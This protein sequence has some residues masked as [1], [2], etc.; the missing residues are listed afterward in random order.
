M[1]KIN[2]FDTVLTPASF[3]DESNTVNFIRNVQTAMKIL[4]GGN[5]T[6]GLG[7][8]AVREIGTN[9]GEVPL[10]NNLEDSV[11]HAVGS[12]NQE[13]PTN[14]LLFGRYIESRMIGTGDDDL[15]LGSQIKA[16]VAANAGSGMGGGLPG[17]GSITHE[18]LGNLIVEADNIAED[19]V[20]RPKILNGAVHP[21]KLYAP[22]QTATP[23]TRTIVTKRTYTG[24]PPPLDDFEFVDNIGL[25]LLNFSGT[26]QPGKVFTIGSNNDIELVDAQTGPPGPTGPQGPA[27]ADGAQGPQ[28][29]AGADGAQGPVG[30][31][32]PPGPTGPPGSGG[33]GGATIGDG[34]LR[35]GA[36][37]DTGTDETK[38]HRYTLAAT[39]E[40][41]TSQQTHFTDMFV[42]RFPRDGY[43]YD[44]SEIKHILGITVTA[45]DGGF[46]TKTWSF[47]VLEIDQIH[48]ASHDPE[49]SYNEY[50]EWTPFTYVNNPNELLIHCAIWENNL[51]VGTANN[52]DTSG[53]GDP[54]IHAGTV[55]IVQ[56]RP[57]IATVE[58]VNNNP[59]PEGPTGPEGPQ[60]P[61]GP[62]GADGV[63]TGSSRLYKYDQ[64]ETAAN[65]TFE[66]HAGLPAIQR[67]APTPSISDGVWRFTANASENSLTFRLFGDWT[68]PSEQAGTVTGDVFSVKM[69]GV[70]NIESENNRD[71]RI[72][73]WVSISRQGAAFT[74]PFEVAAFS[75]RAGSGE[76]LSFALSKF[77]YDSVVG[78]AGAMPGDV[79]RTHFKIENNR[80]NSSLG[81]DPV[82]ANSGYIDLSFS[83]PSFRTYSFNRILSGEQGPQG[84]QGDQGIQ[85]P[86]GIQ[87]DTGPTGPEGPTGPTGPQGPAG[88]I[89]TLGAYS[90]TTIYNNST[91]SF[92]NVVE[93]TLDED[94]VSGAFIEFEFQDFDTQ[95]GYK[96]NDVVFSDTILSLTE[97]STAPSVANDRTESLAI[98]SGGDS[99]YLWR[100]GAANKLWVRQTSNVGAGLKINK[101]LPYGPEADV[102]AVQAEVDAL[103]PTVLR[104][105][106][107]IENLGPLADLKGGTELWT[108]PSGNS[109]PI[110]TSF[111]RAEVDDDEAFRFND[112]YEGVEFDFIWGYIGGPVNHKVTLRH[113]GDISEDQN[114]PTDI[115]GV[116]QKRILVFQDGNDIMVRQNDGVH[117]IED[118]GMTSIRGTVGVLNDLNDLIIPPD[119]S[120][121]T[122]KLKI[123][124]TPEDGQYATFD[125]DNESLTFVDAPS[126][127]GG[128]GSGNVIAATLYTGPLEVTS[129]NIRS[130]AIA[131]DTVVGT[132]IT[133]FE[134][135]YHIPGQY[136]AHSSQR[137]L[138]TAVHDNTDPEA[139]GM[140]LVAFNP[141]T[142][143]LNARPVFFSKSGNTFYFEVTGHSVT[144]DAIIGY[145]F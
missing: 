140:Q 87:G 143:D 57:N 90:R 76:S 16:Y 29:P 109:E 125:E 121:D 15:W 137:V 45:H 126:G 36:F 77:D 60:G 47:D 92:A 110:G 75:V 95:V 6:V 5:A 44:L 72:S 145:R 13:L 38:E 73:R 88:L 105:T 18:M 21:E 7:S 20:T 80:Q 64:L 1:A 32:G 102:T 31:E 127:G 23:A 67:V 139:G 123:T 34:G 79:L 43:F 82:A 89:S 3:D 112:E 69:G 56:D 104:N 84:I 8:A 22:T 66:R 129:G 10:Y 107:A 91:L 51:Y 68:I 128:G 40:D 132:D 141:G 99:F 70:I 49:G 9:D 62:A 113:N 78:A 142:G 27:G 24:S 106:T 48:R 30:P 11:E 52:P 94:L 58:Y 4:A 17:P 53:V 25:D 119:D 124:G 86:Q 85:G 50:D 103:T 59:G 133:M 26:Q 39:H 41:L 2:I 96:L 135:L 46:T 14:D 83:N 33:G 136:S 93:V 61:I 116:G 28:G 42:V 65:M 108:P 81:E 97:F 111:Y 101:I 118:I 120:I 114:S 98:E 130:A 54:D 55:T 37:L 117:L 115:G 134:L 12:G 74:T 144:I 63:L 100:G 138:A 35:E 71:V 122:N 19:A 131:T